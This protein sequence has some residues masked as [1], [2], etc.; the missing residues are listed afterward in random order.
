[1]SFL[2]PSGIDFWQLVG[3]GFLLKCRFSV[4]IGIGFEIEKCR[5][6]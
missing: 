3:I 6:F 2:E 4:R 1:L 5:P